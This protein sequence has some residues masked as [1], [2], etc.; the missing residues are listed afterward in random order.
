MRL[1]HIQGSGANAGGWQALDVGVQLR[2]LLRASLTLHKWAICLPRN[3]I[4]SPTKERRLLLRP[5]HHLSI[6]DQIQCSVSV[7]SWQLQ[8]NHTCGL[9]FITDVLSCLQYRNI[10]E[11]DASSLSVPTLHVCKAVKEWEENISLPGSH[12]RKGLALFSEKRRV[13]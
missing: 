2:N 7:Y 12:W 6:E 10:F 3:T 11:A 5:K 8:P 13:S 4:L 9:P 1:S